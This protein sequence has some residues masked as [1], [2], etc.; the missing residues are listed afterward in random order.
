[1]SDPI[2]NLLQRLMVSGRNASHATAA[3]LHHDNHRTENKLG[4]SDETFLWVTRDASALRD[5]LRGLAAE[6]DL[7][8]LDAADVAAMLRR[9]MIAAPR[10][11]EAPRTI[12]AES[13]QLVAR[14]YRDWAGTDLPR[15]LLLAL[16]ITTGD[17]PAWAVYADLVATDPPLDS[18]AAVEA[19]TPLWRVKPGFFSELFP[20]LLDAVQHLG[21]AA[22]VLDLTNYLVRQ[23]RLASHP[24]QPR[25]SQLVAL[26]GSLAD[27]LEGFEQRSRE[28][29]VTDLEAARQVAES[30]ALVIA[31]CDTCALVRESA[32]VGKLHRI[33]DLGH[34]R[35]RIEAAAALARLGEES[36]V[37]ALVAL[38]A[39]PT[40]RL[41][42]QAYAGE[43][44]VLDQVPSQYRSEVALAEAELVT[45][46][47]E[48]EFW[49][50][51]PNHCELVD[52][53]SLS[54][55]G[56]DEPQACFLFRFEYQLADG[57]F[58]NLGIAGPLVHSQVA[59]LT[60][61]DLIDV[62][63]VFAGWHVQHDDLRRIEIDSSSARQ[64]MELDRAQRRAAEEGY[65]AFG[66]E[67][68]G[69]YFG[70][71][72]VVASAEREGMRGT[73]IVDPTEIHWRPAGN[74]TRPIDA[75]TAYHWYLG[76]DLL[77]RF[78]EDLR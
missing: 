18:A 8:A 46:L 62:Y 73:V 27:R 26:L 51:P 47:S 7:A 35:L 32:A 58:A 23:G 12:D 55:P 54:W 31:L 36:G 65:D 4:S 16:L 28:A 71:R 15:Q 22:M 30:V 67:F 69:S 39:D 60:G 64:Q 44:G 53:R 76:R 1:M 77:R 78:N 42:A 5:A 61:L 11:T 48:P 50:V 59:D 25:A 20:R 13:A 72:L 3:S 6:S 14:L 74:P 75:E 45:R 40:V 21:V 29:G 9:L 56:Y 38:A 10:S 34:R 63:A 17:G 19:L 49:G 52:S 33:L 41:R 66:P 70:Q 57:V 2:T 68:I 24:A 43:L 37:Q